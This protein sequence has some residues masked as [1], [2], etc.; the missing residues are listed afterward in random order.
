DNLSAVRAEIEQEIAALRDSPPDP[1]ELDRARRWLI[2]NH[3]LGLQRRADLAA[4]IALGEAYGLGWD[5]HEK[6]AER[7]AAIDA[8]AVQQAARVHLDW[9]LAVVAVVQPPA[10]T[11]GAAKRAAGKK[12]K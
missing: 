7:V 1:D 12:L 6:Y 3:E 8:A 5:A 9:N 10:M 11:P 2:G 4:A